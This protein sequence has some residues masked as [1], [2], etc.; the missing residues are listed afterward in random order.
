[1]SESEMAELIGL[2]KEP[3]HEWDVKTGETHSKIRFSLF[4]RKKSTTS[5]GASVAGTTQSETGQSG[6]TVADKPDKATVKTKA[7]T[8][9]AQNDTSSD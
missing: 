4:T 6:T 8:S 3:M 2:P 9:K 7:A 5:A 1:M